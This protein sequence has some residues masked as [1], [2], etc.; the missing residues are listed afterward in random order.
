MQHIH[1]R[2]PTHTVTTDF[3]LWRAHQARRRLSM[4]E[5]RPLTSLGSRFRALLSLF[6]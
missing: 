2:P 6:F 3:T 4:R 1:H 5:K